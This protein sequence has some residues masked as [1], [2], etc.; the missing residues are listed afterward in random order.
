MTYEYK[1]PLQ[2]RDGT[3]KVLDGDIT[4]ATNDNWDDAYDKRVD[5]WVHPLLFSENEASLDTEN[6]GIHHEGL[7]GLSDDD[8]TQYF[9]D[10]SI[11]VRSED[12]ST[13]GLIT[14]GEIIDTGLDAD[15]GIYT[16]LS[17]QLTSTIPVNGTLGY[18][19]RDSEDGV[20]TL[21]T[22]TDDLNIKETII[23]KRLLAGGVE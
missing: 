12:Y 11:G 16:D 2:E 5:T 4:G 14:S 7:S 6:S 17:K 3:F 9:A 18:W 8:H 21:A 19:T 23:T 13:T 20:V 15:S 22:A 10:T 1:S